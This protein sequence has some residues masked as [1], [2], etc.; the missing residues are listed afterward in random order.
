VAVL[1]GYFDDSGTHSGSDCIVFAGLLSLADK[2]LTFNE[3][4]E[5]AL[6]DF[7]L[8]YFHM[9]DF[10]GGYREYEHWEPA[11]K[12]ERLERL[13]EIINSNIMLSVG[14]GIPRAAFDENIKDQPPQIFTH[15]YSLA[16]IWCIGMITD[17]FK[18]ILTGQRFP[19]SEMWVSYRLEDGTKGKGEILETYEMIKGNAKLLEESRI[20]SIGFE[21]KRHVLPLQAAD[22]LAHELYRDFTRKPEEPESP[23]LG[24][25][26]SRPHGWTKLKE[27]A[28]RKVGTR[29][30]E[31]HWA[32][33][34]ALLR[35]KT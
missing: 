7:G 1:H 19:I 33:L 23:A 30:Q 9:A 18:Q 10:V 15:P 11:Q 14:I 27:D 12:Q 5:S 21:P 4:W 3:Q 32:I 29:L 35:E 28:V 34:M 2:W 8:D 13:L 25:L 24:L 26:R 16:V 6:N 20:L 22:I 17:R 31:R